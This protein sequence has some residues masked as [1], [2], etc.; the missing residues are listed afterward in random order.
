[1]KIALSNATAGQIPNYL[2][3]KHNT[4]EALPPAPTL[5]PSAVRQAKVNRLRQAIRGGRY[6]IDSASVAA[7][8]TGKFA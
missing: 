6:H 8:I 7:S 2:T 5:H 1:M 4:A 3:P